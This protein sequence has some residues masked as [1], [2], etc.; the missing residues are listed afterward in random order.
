MEARKRAILDFI[1]KKFD[2]EVVDF[3][4]DKAFDEFGFESY[5]QF[6]DF[7][8]KVI[9]SFDEPSL[10]FVEI[11]KLMIEN[12][13]VSMVDKED[14]WHLDYSKGWNSEGFYF[15]NHQNLTIFH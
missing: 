7:Q 8:Q 1:R 9:D 15:D 6:I 10:S 14:L 5:E 3:E 11:L 2:D 4:N 12:N 13:K